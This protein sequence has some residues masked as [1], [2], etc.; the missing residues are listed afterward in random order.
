MFLRLTLL[1]NQTNPLEFAHV[2]QM[3]DPAAPKRFG[4]PGVLFSDPY[5]SWMSQPNVGMPSSTS[6]CAPENRFVAIGS[7]ANTL[8]CE[9]RPCTSWRLLANWSSRSAASTSLRP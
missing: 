6:S 5:S 8:S 9:R 1:G 4:G 3:N 2:K 7:A